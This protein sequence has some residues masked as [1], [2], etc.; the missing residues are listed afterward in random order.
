VTTVAHWVLIIA[1]ALAL[2]AGSLYAWPFGPCP[3]CK[4]SGVNRGSNKRRFGE[5]PRCR[6][7]RRVQRRGSRTVHRIAWT[8]RGEAARARQRRR[9]RKAEQKAEHPRRLMD[10]N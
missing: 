7:R 6:G 5:C 2:W 10:D 9:D 4:G 8:I 1:A 3:R